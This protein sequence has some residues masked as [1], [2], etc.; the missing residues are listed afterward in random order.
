MTENRTPSG[1]LWLAPLTGRFFVV[2]DGEA[3]TAASGVS[4]T[5]WVADLD[6]GAARVDLAAW[7][8]FEVDESAARALY[9]SRLSTG[10][11]TLAAAGARATSALTTA[12]PGLGALVERLAEGDSDAIDGPTAL[13]LLSGRP[14]AEVEAAPEAARDA[15][16]DALQRLASLSPP[17]VDSP[18][19]AAGPVPGTQAEREA[20]GALVA[21]LTLGVEVEPGAEAV[22][23]GVRAEAAAVTPGRDTLAL[24]A[25]LRRAVAALGPQDPPESDEARLD[26]YRADARESI[27]RATAGW[28][29]PTPTVEELLR[30]G[31]DQ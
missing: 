10:A 30:M 29:P 31:D 20:F 13:A 19:P 28:K 22:A 11:A 8:A 21:R 25:T 17:A 2:P 23:F 7:A 12:L 3:P 1:Q 26:R 14:R 4:G 15:V 27:A 6:V 24:L 16:L 9:R 5:D 18:Q